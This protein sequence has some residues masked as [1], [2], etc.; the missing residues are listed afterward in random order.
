MA[1]QRLGKLNNSPYAYSL[2]RR[3]EGGCIPHRLFRNG[4]LI[5]PCYL[6]DCDIC[7]INVITIEQYLYYCDHSMLITADKID[8]Y[9]DVAEAYPGFSAF[10]AAFGHIVLVREDT[11]NWPKR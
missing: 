10:H 6:A 1:E 3:R 5:Q 4:S 9:K 11:W 7:G 2:R 8:N